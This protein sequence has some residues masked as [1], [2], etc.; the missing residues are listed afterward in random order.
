MTKCLCMPSTYVEV[1]D[2]E[3]EFLSASWG[4]DWNGFLTVVGGVCGVIAGIGACVVAAGTGNALGVCMGVVGIVGGIAT[5]GAGIAV[6]E[7]A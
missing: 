3:V 1:K 6:L 2:D 7:K 5:I 4:W